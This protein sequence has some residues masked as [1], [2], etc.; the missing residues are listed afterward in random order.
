MLVNNSEIKIT[1]W[2]VRGLRKLTK[3]KQVINRL[4]HLRSKI[5]F[6]QETHLMASDI[7]C[8]EKRWPGQVIYSSYNNYARG[9]AILVHK[10]V[11]FQ[12]TQTI[13]DPTGR[14]VIAQ[15]NIML[16]KVNLINIY[17]PN[18]DRPS[19][20]EGL[21]L[22][23]STLEGLYI[24]GG[25]FNCTLDPVMDRLTGT[26]IS[27]VQTR[28]KLTE[29]IKDLRLVDVWREKNPNKKEFSC[30]SSTYKTYSRIDY[31]L[32]SVELLI[33]VANCWYDSIVI[34]DHAAASMEISLGIFAQHSQ[35]WRFQIYW[36]QD[37]SFLKF[38]GAC[39]DNYF[40]LNTDET[41]ASVRWEAFKA[42]IRGEIIKYTSSK[43]KQHKK[44]IQTLE[45]QIKTL[46]LDLYENIDEDKQQ[47][48]AVMRAQYNKLTT[49]KVA[50]TLLWTKQAYYDQGEKPSKLLAWRVKKMQ[51]ERTINSIT[52]M[53]G[54]LTTDPIEINATFRNFYELLYK[55]EYAGATQQQTFLD[56]LQF[57]SL[58]GDEME[59]LDRALTVED[60]YDA[61]SSMN[62]GKAP[63][64]DGIPIEFYKKFKQKLAQPLLDMFNESYKTGTLPP[65]LRLA[66]ITVILKPD[67]SPT[68]C[69]SFRP[70]SLM[71]CDTKILC[72]ALSKRLE[73]YLPQL[74]SN[75]QNGFV[76]QRQG[77]HNIRRVLNVLFEKNNAKD[78]AMLSVDASQAFDRIEWKYLFDL[79]PRYGLGETFLKWIKLLYT[80]PTAEILTNNTISKPFSLQRSTRQGCP[81]SPLLFTLAIEPLAIAVRTRRNIFGIRIWDIEHHIALYADDI[82][83]FLTNLKSSIPN[84]INLLEN[85]G[86]FSGYRI[87]KSKSVLLF[88][89]EEERRNPKINTPFMATQEGF[90][91]LGIKIAPELGDIVPTN[92]NPLVD[93]VTEKLD[94]WSK[95]PISMIGRINL[96]KMSI[97]PKFIYLFQALP[98]PLPSNFHKK[99]DSIFTQFIWNNRKGRLRLKLLFLPYERGGLRVP[100]LKWYYWAAQLSSAMYYFSSSTPP[101]WVNIEQKSVS[102]LPIKQYLYSSDVK[103][104]KKQTRNPFVKNTISV[105]YAAHNFVDETITL[106]RFTP[107]WGNRQ[108]RPGRLDGGF[109]LWAEKGIGTISDLYFEGT[110]LR[111]D[112]LCQKYGIPQKHFF[113]YLQ[114]RSFITSKHNS[115]MATPPLSIIEETVI[116]NL[117]GNKHISRFY[118]LLA[119]YST[120]SA[121]DKL[122]AWRTDTQEDISEEDWGGA[123]LK[124]QTNS[125]NTSLKL[126]QY[127]WLM[128]VY[129]TPAKLHRISPNIP[130]VCVKCL[131]EKGTLIHCLWGCSKI[132][133]FW[134]NVVKCLSQM[135]KCNIPLTSTVCILG[136]YPKDF[137]RTTKQSKMIDFGLLHARR[138]IALY[139]KNVEPPSLAIWKK[140]LTTCLGLERLTYIVKGKQ[141]KFACIWESFMSF[142]TNE[143]DNTD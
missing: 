44:E 98:L 117:N 94:R 24:F 128:R 20:F 99:I 91:Y 57:Q 84:L 81:L 132:L 45:R 122:N 95:L 109:K 92:Y 126:I 71:G 4:K 63:G 97:I 78:T 131:T 79:L 7:P 33:N 48:L 2:N 120:E 47:Q 28:R 140:E 118:N 112:Q 54:D 129:I 55:S 17:G 1:S 121:S 43:T 102:D 53:S 18:E 14:Y 127:K 46:E 16:Y 135:V 51:A 107:I 65:S 85:F 106:S 142:L 86:E 139:W 39:I 90:K 23:V 104:L 66:M 67:K 114:L 13:Q 34:S 100:N 11:P 60:L 12:I 58:S 133:V 116:N 77:F 143:T 87:N 101:A 36:L 35:R 72:K 19:F 82:I 75:D 73:K 15:G 125:I 10:S 32:I 5:V 30:H 88:L 110:L 50:K 8:L 138:V 26:D 22:T 61:M 64:P 89:N 69:S 38:M 6:L 134:E 25:D 83:F 76:L 21:L 137:I 124:A 9:V 52:T 93:E 115:F 41:T 141:E 62:S 49:D 59:V 123:C 56:Q 70:I 113:K 103:T 3:L 37:S 27:H 108:F 80:N 74:I 96:I 68:S 29:F 119:E 40:L 136:I 105:W 130:D 111:F 31:F 42:Y